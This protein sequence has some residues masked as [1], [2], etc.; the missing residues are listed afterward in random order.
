[1]ILGS[2]A[3]VPLLFA[4]VVLILLV[5]NEFVWR[6]ARQAVIDGLSK[7]E[8]FLGKA[9]LIPVLGIAFLGTYLVT[10]VGFAYAATDAAVRSGA[11]IHATHVSAMGGLVL[12]FVGYAASA[13]F[14]GLAIRN[15][16][17]AVG[18]WMLYGVLEAILSASL[19]RLSV[20]MGPIVHYFPMAVFNKL[21]NYL[22]YDPEALRTAV[23]L[24]ARRHQPGPDVWGLG[25]LLPV[26]AAWI[27]LL[28]GT[29]VVWFRKRDL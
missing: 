23:E 27:G 25:F 9:L 24:A 7:G 26:A 21:T 22:E 6:T 8:V 20:H 29:A 12:A 13:L 28:L 19:V 15:P 1:M 16:G 4:S 18:V 17:S 11:L 3:M 10:G 5:S 2:L 14:V